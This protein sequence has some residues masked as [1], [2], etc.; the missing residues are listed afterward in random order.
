MSENTTSNMIKW[1]NMCPKIV[2]TSACQFRW[3]KKKNG[4]KVL[5][6]LFLQDRYDWKHQKPIWKD[7]EIMEEV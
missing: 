3:F 6:Q 4:E 5:Q 2:E 1:V 7:I